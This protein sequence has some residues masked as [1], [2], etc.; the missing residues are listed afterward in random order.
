MKFHAFH[1]VM[2]AER[3]IGGAF[4]VDISYDLETNAVE[5]D[6]IKDTISYAV[7]YDIIKAEMQKPSNL[8]EHAA[9]R[10]IKAVKCKFPQ[11]RNTT[12]KISKLNPPINGEAG[13][14]SVSITC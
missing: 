8:I 4:L 13:K 12:V 1:G 7:V 9:G 14:A 5:T 11:I 2:E 6:D 3:I 10:I